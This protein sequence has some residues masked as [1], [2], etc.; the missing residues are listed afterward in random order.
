MKKIGIADLYK[1]VSVGAPEILNENIFFFE[2]RVLDKED[3]EYHSNIWK[4]NV[5]GRNVSPFTSGK[6]DSSP[7]VNKKTR[8]LAFISR[9]NKESKE[10]EIYVM[11]IDGGEAQKISST[12]DIIL[13]LEWLDK[14]HLGYLALSK[15]LKNGEKEEDKD[16]KEEKDDRKIIEIDKIPF[17][18]NGIGFLEGRTR[19][20]F[21]VD[22][23]KGKAEQLTDYEHIYSLKAS[24]DGNK[25]AFMLLEDPEKHPEI[26]SLYVFDRKTNKMEKLDLNGCSVMAGTEWKDSERI[27]LVLNDLERGFATNGF[28]GIFSLKDRSLDV[29]TK[30]KDI[31]VYNALNSDV[32]G[33]STRDTFSY[34]GDFYFLHNNG[35]NTVISKL[36]DKGNIG[37][38]K[39]VRGSI[40]SINILSD[41]RYVI[42]YMDS[43]KPLEVYTMSG[44]KMKQ[45]TNF[46]SWIEDYMLS[47]PEH[48]TV[49]ASDG[50]KI[51]AWIMK[52][53]DFEEGE[54]YPTIL[55]I[56]GGPKTAYGYSFIHEMQLLASEGYA[57]L[58]CNPRGS[59]GYSSEFADIR[60]HYG[61][62]D[63][64][65]IMEVV[66]KALNSFEFIDDERLG[67][68]GG[69][70]GGFMTNWIVGHTDIFKAAVTQRS[71]SNW[72]SFY[73]T[74]DIGYYFGKDQVGGNF[75]DNEEGYRRQ[76][77]LTYV[78]NVETPLLLIHSLEDFRC[79]VPEAMQFFTA[80]RRLGK[81]SRMVLFPGENHELSRGGKPVHREKRLAEIVKW[82]DDHLKG[83][84]NR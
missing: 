28:M 49:K 55:E 51:D 56:H 61:E 52:P 3:N 39:E 34:K 27:Y 31:P 82:F 72:T 79:W 14:N 1:F 76:S 26:F 53:V 22:I 4:A 5:K 41:D 73:G 15:N 29:L 54:K 75:W 84:K 44:G 16:N 33:G 83:G 37:K 36:D 12:K 46:N 78:S 38:I 47:K 40:D 62:R 77:P 30:D 19:K 71:I 8:K 65:D 57:V 7:K 64:Q 9:R 21:V 23:E 70:Y 58:F 66:E 2:K 80:L 48:F 32:R 63:F 68:T 6:H 35:P 18:S 81:E 67:V 17:V 59:H 43:Q 50:E 42:N 13:S 74:T 60:K 25:V 11:N 45:L 20:A 10:S 69:S 24:P